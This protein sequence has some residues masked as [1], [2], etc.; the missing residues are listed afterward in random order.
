MLEATIVIQI[1]LNKSGEAA[2]VAMLLAVN[3]AVSFIVS[4][5]R[6]PGC[7]NVKTL[8]LT[9][10]LLAA[11]VLL[12]PVSLSLI[13]GLLAVVAAYLFVLDRLKVLIFRSLKIR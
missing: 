2:I 1:L 10:G 9:G 13:G 8:M 5:S 3:A 7:W 11:L 12:A 4:Y 6:K